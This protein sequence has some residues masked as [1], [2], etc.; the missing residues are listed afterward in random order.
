MTSTGHRA[1]A[2]ADHAEP[3][4]VEVERAAVL[5]LLGVLAYGELSAFDRMAADARMAPTVAA[6]AALSGMAA[7]EISH[8]DRLV[9]RI[10][11]H[12]PRRGRGAV[13]HDG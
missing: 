10:S 12:K 8:Y 11:G 13:D 1:D 9:A 2:D 5:D 3:P 6:R 4:P 7:V